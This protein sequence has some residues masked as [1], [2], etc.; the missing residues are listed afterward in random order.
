MMLQFCMARWANRCLPSNMEGGSSLPLFVGR[1]ASVCRADSRILQ[2][3]MPQTLV[4]EEIE[5]GIHPSRLRLLVELL[6]ARS[7]EDGPQ[8]MASTHS[9][10]VAFFV[11]TTKRQASR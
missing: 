7:S 10:V 6:N 5:N 4:L 11:A 3:D 9:P 2:P 1:H 8:V